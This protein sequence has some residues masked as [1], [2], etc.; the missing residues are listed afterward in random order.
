[1]MAI[2]DYHFITEW[3]IPGTINEVFDVLL[4]DAASLKKWWPSVYLDVQVLE[5][6]DE[7]GVGQKVG[8]FTNG[9]LPYT[10][11]WSFVVTEAERPYRV[12]L[13]AVG[14]FVGRGIWTLEQDGD[15][16]K[17]TYDWKVRADKA[18]LETFSFLMK[19][20]FTANHRW[21]MNMGEKSLLLEL[22]R[23][24]VSTPEEAVKIPPPPPPAFH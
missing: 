9:W 24:R 1:M 15:R 7:R 19:P 12:A 22:Q 5:K 17:L 10:L 16:V 14:D 13:E 23:R 3:H 11:R 18:L 20:I 6:R 21:A 8:L 2:N 4:G